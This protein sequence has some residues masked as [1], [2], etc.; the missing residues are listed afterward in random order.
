[1]TM[2]AAHVTSREYKIMLRAAMFT[3]T[4][5][6]V[7]RKADAFRHASE[8][9]IRAVAF[10]IDGTLDSVSKRRRIRFVDTP[11]QHLRRHDYILRERTDVVTGQRETTLKFR[12]PDRYVAQDCHLSTDE[13]DWG[14]AKFEED[15]KP[16]H[17]SLY[18]FSTTL[19]I[20][21]GRRLDRLKDATGLYPGLADQLPSIDGHEPISTVGASTIREL[22]L[23]GA[24]IQIGRS[25]KVE[26]K[27]ALIV[28]YDLDKD[29]ESPV[30]VEFSFRYGDKNEQYAGA[31]ARHAHDA[32][33]SLQGPALADWVDPESMTKT[34]YVYS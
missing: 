2:S 20:G 22:V 13:P 4:E 17:H 9:P 33:L 14:T 3:G 25:P 28:W 11:G 10:D 18:S 31:V 19:E 8:T 6:I 29:P 26:A 1:M 12:H 23:T 16:P 5:D 32:F 34:S 30:V 21:A 7:L 24:D 15:I 27:C